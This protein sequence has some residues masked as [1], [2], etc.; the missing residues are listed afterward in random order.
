VDFTSNY[1]EIFGLP[2]SYQVDLTLLSDRYR[3]MQRKFHPD[4]YASKPAQEQRLAVQYAAVIN[5][6][7]TELSSP[8][9]RA[10][11]LLS[12]QN[13]D[14]AGDVK[15]TRDPQF[16]M[17]QIEL[18]EKLADLSEAEANDAFAILGEV[19]G[20]AKSDYIGLQQVFDQQYS[21]SD[22]Q[23]AEE[24]VAKMQ[25]FSKLLNETEQLEQEL[26]D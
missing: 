3:S 14:G 9:L 25:F 19:A 10:Q 21:H 2:V 13:M 4:R 17:Q 7:Y 5:Q 12:L 23:G 8:L 11:Y 22:F 16:L 15:I 18:R 26:D 24:T 1:F 6:A 20:Q